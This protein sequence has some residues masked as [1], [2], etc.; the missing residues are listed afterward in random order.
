MQKKLLKWSQV[1]ALLVGFVHMRC[2]KL[3]KAAETWKA[4]LLAQPI[5]QGVPNNAYVCAIII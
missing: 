4:G 1:I 5:D 2:G 3:E